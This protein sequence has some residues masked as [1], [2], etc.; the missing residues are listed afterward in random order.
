M[1]HDNEAPCDNPACFSCNVGVLSG[2]DHQRIMRAADLAKTGKSYMI[3][4]FGD[5]GRCNIVSNTTEDFFG[6][7][8]AK[9]V[10]VIVE[11]GGIP[12]NER[13]L[14]AAYFAMQEPTA[15]DLTEDSKNLLQTIRCLTAYFEA[16]H[17]DSDGVTLQ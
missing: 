12:L 13:A 14:K 4:I 15:D 2:E 6:L 10:T 5:Q 3:A 8:I 9:F 7:V 1:T 17:M 16:L 11:S